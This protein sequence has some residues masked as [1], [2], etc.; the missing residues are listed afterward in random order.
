MKPFLRIATWNLLTGGV[1][2]GDDSR[3]HKQLDALHGVDADVVGIQEAN[4]WADGGGRRLREVERV[5]GMRGFLTKSNHHGCDLALLVRESAG[6][7][8]I[9]EEHD[10]GPPWWHA[11]CHV[12]TE[13]DGFPGETHLLV[14]HLAPGSPATR[15]CEAESFDLFRAGHRQTVVVGDWN[16]AALNDPVPADL[17]ACDEHTRRKSD[18]RPAKALDA[19]GLL[20]A[21]A[22]LGDT[23]PTLSRATKDRY[24]YR[25]DRIYTTLPPK[26][27]IRHEVINTGGL[28]DHRL[29]VAD[30][31]RSDGGDPR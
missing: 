26:L 24:V 4:T 27:I 23:T 14:A 1:D 17:A 13:I 28:S 9:A 12:R 25:C 19:A 3:L 16:A 29:V 22:H 20:D 21:G 18:V 7:H 15:L 11:L 6:I 2:S 30:I 31:A 5:L 10:H 8:V